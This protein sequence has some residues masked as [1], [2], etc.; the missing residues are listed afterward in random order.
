MHRFRNLMKLNEKLE[1]DLRTLKET[2]LM[3]PATRAEFER[4]K[5]MDLD[6]A[7]RER[8]LKNKPDFSKLDKVLAQR[9]YEQLVNMHR[10]TPPKR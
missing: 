9:R 6:P 5:N 7:E 1:E 3:G 10:N 4:R 8:K 2:D